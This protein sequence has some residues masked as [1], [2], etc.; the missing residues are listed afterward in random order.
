MAA[1][2]H[3]GEIDGMTA[4]LEPDAVIDG[5][6]DGFCAAMKPFAVMPK[7]LPPAAG[8]PSV[9]SVCR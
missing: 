7:W 9:S 1:L 6:R 4:L 2:Q 8:L 3:A 5:G